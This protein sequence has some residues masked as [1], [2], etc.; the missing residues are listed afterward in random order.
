[1]S[2]VSH[3][4]DS[5]TAM[6][7]DSKIISMREEQ[8]SVILVGESIICLSENMD[9]RVFKSRTCAPYGSIRLILRSPIQ[10]T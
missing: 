3:T 5:E 2:I 9:M 10:I 6:S 4:P 8:C 1:M 7:L